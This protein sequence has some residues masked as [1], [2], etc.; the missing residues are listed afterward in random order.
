MAENSK[1]EWTDSSVNPIRAR[2]R[3]ASKTGH[4]CIHVSPGCANCYSE[5]FQTRFGNPVRF[6]AQDASKVGMFLDEAALLM[7]LRWRKPRRIFWNSM[8]DLFG[9]WVPD[10]WIDRHLAVMALAPQHTFQILT[11]RPERMRAYMTDPGVAQRV[12]DQVCDLAL[13]DARDIT[14]VLIADPEH[15]PH[16]PPGRRIR[17]GVWPLPNV[18]LGVS[19]ENQEWA[20]RRRDDLAALAAAGWNTFVSYEP[21][22]GPIDWRGWEFLR[23]L[24]SGG[25]SGPK[26]RPSHPDWHRAARDFCAAHGIPYFF[27]QWG[28]YAPARTDGI[29]FVTDD[30][31]GSVT[32]AIHVAR[33]RM[34]GDFCMA[35]VGKSRAGR[36]LDGRE[37]NEVPK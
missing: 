34:R 30:D 11:K 21:A 33:C 12:Y 32:P 36:L 1:I 15:E 16:A 5:R 24:I 35:R 2:N 37:W 18:W 28:S 29:G 9:D 6:A 8:T 3:K 13:T 26:A 22:L 19:V 25:E 7:P 17:L 23:W 20:D 14:L 27:K 10:D 31:D 4:F